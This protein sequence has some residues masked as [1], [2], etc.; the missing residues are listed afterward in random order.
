MLLEQNGY[1][2]TREK[3]TQSEAQQIKQMEELLKT[4]WISNRQA[5]QELKSSS[6]DRVLRRVRERF[7]NGLINGYKW[8]QRKKDC[9]TYCLEYTLVKI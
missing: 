9:K 5:Q 4:R 6:G 2:I 3:Y 8:E 7:E 1:T